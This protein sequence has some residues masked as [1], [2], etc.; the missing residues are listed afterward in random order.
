MLEFFFYCVSLSGM[1]IRIDK[2]TKKPGWI[3]SGATY[4]LILKDDV[5]YLLRTGK[6]IGFDQIVPSFA[7]RGIEGVLSSKLAGMMISKMNSD[8]L[9]EIEAFEPN[10][11][12]ENLDSL[13]REKDCYLI[14]K[15]EIEEVNFSDTFYTLKLKTKQGKFKFY[16]STVTDRE[17]VKALIAA[18]ETNL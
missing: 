5:L 12:E 8:R 18:L 13:A 1:E 7:N 11:S 9:K 3:K 10:I 15:S 16:F 6:Y 4:T 2:V 17:K 14:H